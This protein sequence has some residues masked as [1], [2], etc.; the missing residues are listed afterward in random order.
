MSKKLLLSQ[1]FR[2]GSSSQNENKVEPVVQ[3]EAV[4]QEV[5]LNNEEQRIVQPPTPLVVNLDVVTP[6]QPGR[7][8]SFPYR[9]FRASKPPI[10]GHLVASGSSCSLG[11]T[12]TKI[13]M[14]RFVTPVC[15]LRKKTLYLAKT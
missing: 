2:A 7:S 13:L 14:P 1:Y 9:T 3:D 5:T 11:F 8:Y 10:D 6:N 15:M 4:P 12:M